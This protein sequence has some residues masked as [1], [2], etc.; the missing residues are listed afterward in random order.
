MSQSLFIIARFTSGVACPCDYDGLI[1]P[2]QI[3]TMPRGEA[4][5]WVNV[6]AREFLLPI[7]K[8]KNQRFLQI[9]FQSR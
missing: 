4:R 8:K 6:F 7:I 5:S 9:E 3:L 2:P 1:V